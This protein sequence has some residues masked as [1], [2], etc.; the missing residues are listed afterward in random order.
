MIDRLSSE[1]ADNTELFEMSKAEGDDAGMLAIEED[2]AKVAVEV[3]KMEFRRMFNTASS[4]RLNAESP[5][6][7]ADRTVKTRSAEATPFTAGRGRVFTIE[8]T[9]IAGPV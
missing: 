5:I 6:R 8:Y 1:L 9:S 4:T 7:N 2:A 3:E